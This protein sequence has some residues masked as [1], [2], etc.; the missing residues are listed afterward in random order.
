[1]YATRSASLRVVSRAF[2]RSSP[3][4]E[5]NRIVRRF[6]SYASDDDGSICR[7]RAKNLLCSRQLNADTVALDTERLSAM[8]ERRWVGGREVE[9]GICGICV[10]FCR[11]RRCVFGPLGRVASSLR[12]PI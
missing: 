10:C 2:R 4:R 7:H 9:G 11:A 6:E 12:H 1:M 8:E 5:K 3:E